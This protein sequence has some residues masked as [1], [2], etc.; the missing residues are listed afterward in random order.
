MSSECWS[1]QEL[2]ELQAK[3]AELRAFLA[4]GPL[5]QKKAQELLQS[6]VFCRSMKESQLDSD[7]LLCMPPE[8]F[9]KLAESIEALYRVNLRFV[10]LL[11]ISPLWL[12]EVAEGDGSGVLLETLP[13]A[14]LEQVFQQGL[15]DGE[16]LPDGIVENDRLGI[17]SV[18]LRRRIEQ[19]YTQLGFSDLEHNLETAFEVDGEK[20]RL[21]VCTKEKP[22]VKFH[23]F[24]FIPIN[25]K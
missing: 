6:D 21:V 14:L 12:L 19:V 13:L 20:Q 7:M 8:S 9:A 18:F 11:Q 16:V 23:A 15:K 17:M 2:L 24:V 3:E 10:S 25:P 5:A 1:A 4:L 22:E